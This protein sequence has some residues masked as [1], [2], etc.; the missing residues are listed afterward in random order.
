[1][2]N[3]LGFFH[4]LLG[5][6]GVV[7][8]NVEKQFLNERQKINVTQKSMSTYLGAEFARVE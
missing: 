2:V 5:T 4:V 8:G 1:M 3:G 7:Y 6:C